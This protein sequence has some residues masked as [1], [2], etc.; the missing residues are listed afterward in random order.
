MANTS[1]LSVARS[2]ERFRWDAFV[3][4]IV[5]FW[6]S[7][8]VLIDFLFMPMMYEAGMMNDPGFASGGYS[9]FWLFNRVELLC[10]ATILTGL[11]VLK[12]RRNEF[13][14]VVSGARSRWA[15]MTGGMLFAITL[16]Y[17]YI[18]TPHMSALGINLSGN[19]YEAMPPEMG[20]MHLAYWGLEALKL[21][22]TGLLM[23]LCYRDIS[24]R[25]A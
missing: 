23:R 18:L 8:S 11:L 25:V 3:L 19:I 9:L 15:L 22:G 4:L 17:T 10:A 5:T 24:G 13:E 1:N 14:V 21:V 2:W 20:L 12:K 16:A 6:L 7:S